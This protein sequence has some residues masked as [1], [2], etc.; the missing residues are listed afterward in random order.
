MNVEGV[1]ETSAQ[2]DRVCDTLERVEKT[3]VSTAVRRM[4]L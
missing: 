4:V 2:W 1:T 3:P